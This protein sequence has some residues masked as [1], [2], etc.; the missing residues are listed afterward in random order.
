MDLKDL[1]GEDIDVGK[2]YT[3]ISDMTA[4]IDVIH[5]QEEKLTEIE[6]SI[7]D[8]LKDVPKDASGELKVNLMNGTV[9]VVLDEYLYLEAD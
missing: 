8:L 2:V 3:K 5:E 1:M 7:R 4:I 6:T 9:L